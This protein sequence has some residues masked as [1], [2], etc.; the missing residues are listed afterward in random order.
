VLKITYWDIKIGDFIKVSGQ[1]HNA[2]EITS[3]SVKQI[4]MRR[5]KDGLEHCMETERVLGMINENLKMNRHLVGE[6]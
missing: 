3:K 6:N 4:C 2:Y 5:M 1:A